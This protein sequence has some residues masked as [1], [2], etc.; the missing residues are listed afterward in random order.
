[1]A[2]A[3]GGE[4]GDGRAELEVACEG[5]PAVRLGRVEPGDGLGNGLRRQRQ[6]GVEVLHPEDGVSARIGRGRDAVDA[7]TDDRLDSLGPAH[8]SRQLYAGMFPA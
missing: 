4:V 8:G 5:K 6:V 7:E 2:R 1:V 3:L